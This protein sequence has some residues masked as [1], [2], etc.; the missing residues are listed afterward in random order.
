MGDK[1][2]MT[3]TNWSALADTTCSTGDTPAKC[4]TVQ[5]WGPDKG[6]QASV[7]TEHPT[8]AEAFAAIDALSAQTVQTGAPIVVD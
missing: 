1:S 8:V 4:R 5:S 2:D 7:L 3:R 6:R